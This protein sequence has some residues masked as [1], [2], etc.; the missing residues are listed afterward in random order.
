MLQSVL[1][2]AGAP[3]AAAATPWVANFFNDANGRALCV[4][5]HGTRTPSDCDHSTVV[6][7]PSAEVM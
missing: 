3:A 5:A 1:L 6:Y 2:A 7:N 4:L